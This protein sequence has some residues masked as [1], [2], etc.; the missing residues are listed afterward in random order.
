MCVCVCVCVC[1]CMCHII[2]FHLSVDGHLGCFQ[3]L[4][5]VSNAAMNIGMYVSFRISVF[6]FFGHITRTALAES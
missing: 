6:I 5:T 4:V 1:V 2:F 3:I